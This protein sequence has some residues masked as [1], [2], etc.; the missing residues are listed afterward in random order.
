MT[1]AAAGSPPPM[2]GKVLAIL[3]LSLFDRITPTHVGK[4]RAK[5]ER[6]F[7]RQ[8][9]PHPCGEKQIMILGAF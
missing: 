6:D 5:F 8:D 4:R 2:W 3:W 1:K 9:H 7:I